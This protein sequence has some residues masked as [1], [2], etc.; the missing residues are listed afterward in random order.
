MTELS[1]A[2]ASRWVLLRGLARESGHWGDFPEHLQASIPNS[3][4]I[5]LDLP[6]AGR[7]S[8]MR[9]FLSIAETTRFVRA[10]YQ[11]KSG[12]AQAILRTHLVAI[13]LGGMVASEWL[14]HWPED[15]HSL[16]LI[17]TSFKGYSPPYKRLL[18]T[19]YRYLASAAF[20]RSSENREGHIFD[21][22][23][24]RPEL[25]AKAVADWSRLH[26]LRPMSVENILRQLTAAALF[27]TALEKS[28]CPTLILGSLADRMV[29]PSCSELI[30][31]RWGAELRQHPTSGHDLPL[32]QP[33]WVA[34]QIHQ[35]WQT[36]R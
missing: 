23:S 12:D 25:K 36:L 7:F 31:R 30:A 13:S 34:S 33:E 32:D 16:T 21:M 22:V 29:S 1:N 4:V 8:E 11:E 9:S 15:F 27:K 14:T 10:Q 3:T 17:N 6:G 5:T 2:P 35:F 18:F 26:N 24:N 20:T 19:S 28:P